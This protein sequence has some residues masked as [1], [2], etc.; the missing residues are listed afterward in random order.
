[1]AGGGPSTTQSTV[2][3]SNLPAYAKPYYESMM[4]RAMSES[5]TDYIPYGGDRIADMSAATKTGLNAATA[6]GQ[7]GTALTDAGAN[8]VQNAANKAS[9]VNYQTGTFNPGYTGNELGAFQTGTFNAGYTGTENGPYNANNYQAQQMGFGQGG[10]NNIGTNN[11]NAA[12]AQQYMS[13]YMDAV[14]NKAQADAVQNAAEA[15]ATRNLQAA[16]SGSFGGSRAAV[17]QQMANNALQNNLTD[18]MVKGQ[19]SAFENAQTQFNADQAR[20]LEAARANQ[21]AG[22]TMGQANQQAALEAAKL[23]EQS[24]QYGYDASQSALQKAADLRLAAQQ[25]AE[26]SRQFGRETQQSALQKAADMRLQAQQAAEQSRQFGSDLTMKGLDLSRQA[27]MDLNSLQ[28]SKD[29]ATMSRIKSLLGVGTTMEDY[30]QQELDQRYSDFVNQR[31]AERQNLQFLS[32]I[33]QGVP[34]SAN[35]D[36]TTSSG[37]GNNLQ[38]LLGSVGG[39]QSLM[40]LGKQ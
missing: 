16:K 2:T 20:A 25:A 35:Q 10:V 37:G 27:G 24:S 9:N 3:Q 40:A 12:A 28:Q 14:V 23:R 22:L 36:V 13:P 17:Q 8:A 32:S 26:Q 5:T 38:G 18:I 11:F 1:M 34:I 29:D 39:L 7:S 30:Q 31:D 21:S 4:N 15:Q 19:Q 33:L 6:Y